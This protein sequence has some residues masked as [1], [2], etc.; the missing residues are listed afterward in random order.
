[1]LRQPA[2]QYTAMESDYDLMPYFCAFRDLFQAVAMDLE[3]FVIHISF[4]HTN[5]P[6]P[7][8][9]SFPIF[10]RP[11]ARLR[12]L[13]VINLCD[14]RSL[15][16]SDSE[17]GVLFPSLSRLHII[18][19][20]HVG[21]SPWRLS[22]WMDH[23]PRTTHLRLSGIRPYTCHAFQRDIQDSLGLSAQELWSPSPGSSNSPATAPPK[24]HAHLRYIAFQCASAVATGWVTGGRDLT[25]FDSWLARLVA[26][27]AYHRLQVVSLPVEEPARY[28]WLFGRKEVEQ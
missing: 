5:R 16:D 12:E 10:T 24:T 22:V 14:P 26:Y 3:S 1:M 11:F 18:P 20:R 6:A 15:L 19:S 28:P 2:L 21:D 23:A 13:T 25:R 9:F 17:V 8:P 4:A 7:H 27:P